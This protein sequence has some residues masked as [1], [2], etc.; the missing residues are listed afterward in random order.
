MNL[1]RLHNYIAFR[2]ALN[3]RERAYHRV[4]SRTRDSTIVIPVLDFS[5]R[6]S[7]TD[8]GLS[9]DLICDGIREPHSTRHIR[10]VLTDNDIVLD[11]G[12]NIGYYTLVCAHAKKI[13]AYEPSLSNYTLLTQNI[14]LN[15][16]GHVVAQRS[17]V[18]DRFG[19]ARLNISA[20][21]NLHTIRNIDA[22]FTGTETVPVQ[23]LSALIQTKKPTFIRMDVEG[24]EHV[25]LK[26]AQN[27]LKKV[28]RLFI[29]L[30]PHL[31]P[32]HE[33]IELLT[34]MRD[35]GFEIERLFRCFTNTELPFKKEV[36]FDMTID[37]VL[38]NDTILEGTLG[39]FELFL[40]N[41]D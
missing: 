25:I 6:V 24:Y 10:S 40:V 1:K 28:K 34:I 30:H 27:K 18:G 13:Y 32:K 23:P 4:R 12:A 9:K 7:L 36:R 35:T 17:A 2:R 19:T 33:T 3:K 21:G 22:S 29:E 5:M 8:P 41:D 39:A 38:Q 11:I 15:G 20:H 31:I 16:L 14:A 37:D 26:G